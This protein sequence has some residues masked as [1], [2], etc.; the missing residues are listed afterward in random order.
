M[1]ELPKQQHMKNNC[2]LDY[3]LDI[4]VFAGVLSTM[5]NFSLITSHL[6]LLTF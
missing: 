5:T 1:R 3:F 4:M 2:L 6:S